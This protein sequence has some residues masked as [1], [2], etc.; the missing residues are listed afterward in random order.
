MNEALSNDVTSPS[1]DRW[2]FWIDRGGTFTDCVARRPDGT[3]IVRKVLSGPDSV[4]SAVRAA[5]GSDAGA[6][7]PACTLRMGTTVATNALLEGDGARTGLLISRGFADLCQIATGARPA[8][9]ALHFERP[10]PLATRICEVGAR[11]DG[12]G[13]LLFSATDDE[14]EQAADAFVA[15]NVESVAVSILGGALGPEH[16]QDVVSRLTNALK[17]RGSSAIVVRATEVSG[18]L[19][20][21]GR[22]DTAL[23]D[24]RL[25][26]LLRS[27][28]ERHAKALPGAETELMQ[29]SGALCPPALFRGPGAILSGPAGGVVATQWLVREMGEPA[30]IAF[31]MGGTST[32]VS[33]VDAERGLE[34]KFETTVANV[35]VRAPILDIHTVAAGGGS[36]CTFADGTRFEVGPKSVG[37]APGPLCYGAKDAA[38]LSITDVNLCLGRLVAD[39]FPFALDP[40]SPRAALEKIANESERSVEAAGAGFLAVANATMADAISRI[41]L[42]RGVDASKQSLVV[43]GGAGGQHA[44][45]V[46]E[47]LQMRR[48][49]WHPFAGVLSAFGMGL[50]DT[51]ATKSLTA[52]LL[53]LDNSSLQSLGSDVKALREQAKAELLSARTGDVDRARLETKTRLSLRYAKTETDIVVDATSVFANDAQISAAAETDLRDAFEQAHAQRFGTVRSAAPIEMA[54]VHVDVTFRS[55]PP[56][57]LEEAPKNDATALRDHRLF[58]PPAPDGQWH[59]APVFDRAALG[60]SQRVAGPALLLDDTGCFVVDVG[61]EARVH[62]SG[63]IV[64]DRVCRPSE[65]EAHHVDA[66]LAKRDP[67][68]LTLFANAFMACAEQMG[69]VLQKCSL[70]TNIRERLDFSCA[71]FSKT[72]DLIANAPHIPVHLGAMSE[73]VQAVL[74]KHPPANMQPGDAFVTNDPAEGGSHLPDITCVSPVFLDEETA[75]EDGPAFFVA[76]RGHHADVGGTTPGSMPPDSTTLAEEGAVLSALRICR[77]GSLDE[78][79]LRAA[80]TDIPYPARDVEMNLADIQAQLAANETGKRLLSRLVDEWGAEVVH[81]YMDH[82]LDD[83]DE[84]VRRAIAN[85]ELPESGATFSDALDDGTSIC[86][87]IRKGVE[88]A[89]RV[90]DER[91]VSDAPRLVIDF[92]KT[93]PAH[94]GNL[95]APKAVTLACVM[96]S[97]RVLVGDD[98]PLSSGFLRSVD[99]KIPPDSVL[100]PPA[101]KAVAAGNVETSQRVVD[102]LLAA[103]GVCAA[104]QGTMNNV[105]FGDE[106]FGYY[107]TLG[108]GGG[109]GPTFD[110][111][112]AVQVHMTNT[113][114]TDPEL[115]E[116]RHPL[117]VLAL[118]QRRGSG[119]GG[120]HAGGE[121]MEREYEALRDLD[122]SL[123]TERR[124]QAPFGLQ[125]GDAGA[126]GE[127]L[128]DNAPVGGR[129]QLRLKKGQRLLVRTPGG[130]GFGATSSPV[131]E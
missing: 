25:S 16:E 88:D 101:G 102:V 6:P 80:L 52:R 109:A 19:G 117:R 12:E 116:A 125:G 106:S 10:A 21:L 83:A 41:T 18:D 24:A 129:A 94:A 31:D 90:E 79:R 130:G 62:Q 9:F 39:R 74:Q 69:E 70:S 44:C 38:A 73:S 45:A 54:S 76:S 108:G 86:V 64:I 48:V 65:S 115:V 91:T 96:Y 49:L 67:V 104:S 95:N 111:P 56:P 63:T 72:G 82:V 59:S 58:S 22:T 11:V 1:F 33:A 57:P 37:A 23:V 110:G 68:R 8:L 103:L 119:G 99:L 128:V 42:G 51:A 29:S 5:L 50:A 20:L 97:L 34:H 120:R 43:L 66:S 27:T 105:T 127:N 118:R 7:V 71:V 3:L 40:K 35:R 47:R 30:G 55:E 13:N 114:L 26:P 28:L 77:G 100:S 36:V 93:A 17:A 89:G 126:R 113:R 15:S 131:D 112:S 123:L 4:P 60:S 46:A 53:P 98:V 81:A 107:E 121:G 61:W 122:V 78:D 84:R 75:S 32:D 92:A 87:H 124:K 14:V 85:L 2:A